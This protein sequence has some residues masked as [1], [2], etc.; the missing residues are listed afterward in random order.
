M[1]VLLILPFLSITIDTML[2]FDGHCDG[3]FTCKQTFASWCQSLYKYCAVLY[4]DVQ[5]E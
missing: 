5:G 3:D 2:N 1:G 4:A